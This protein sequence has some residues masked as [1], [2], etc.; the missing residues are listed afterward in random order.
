MGRHREPSAAHWLAR[1][2]GIGVGEA[3][4]TLQTAKELDELP[5]TKSALRHGELSPRQAHLVAQAASAD[6][7]AEGIM[8][9]AAK[10][11]SVPE[12]RDRALRTRAAAEVDDMA[13]YR[14]VKRG[15]HFRQ[16][17]DADGAWIGTIRDTPEV[18]ALVVAA[19]ASERPGIFEAARAAGQRDPSEAYDADAFAEI[20]RKHLAR[21]N[22]APVE[23]CNGML[24]ERRNG[25]PPERGE[26]KGL[27]FSAQTRRADAPSTAAIEGR[28]RDVT[29]GRPGELPSGTT[30]PSSE[31]GRSE[32]S[33]SPTTHDGDTAA[34]SSEGLRTFRGTAA[35]STASTREAAPPSGT[36]TSKAGT[37]QATPAS[38]KRARTAN[39]NAA[40]SSC[41]EDAGAELDDRR[42]TAPSLASRKVGHGTGSRTPL[43]ARIDHGALVR[44][45][46]EPGELCEITGVGP[47]PVTVVRD[48]L[49]HAFLAAV[50]TSPD[51][52]VLRVAHLGRASRAAREA[53]RRFVAPSS[54]AG[55]PGSGPA[56]ARFETLGASLKLIVRVPVDAGAAGRA[57][58]RSPGLPGSPAA[59]E[60]DVFLV[61]LAED[62]VEI[63]SAAHHTR[64][65]RVH[66]R[67][68]LEFRDPC[69]A[70][71]GC[72]A[73]ARLE[74]DHREEWSATHATC[75]DGADRLC[76]AHHWL[77][78]HRG[79]RLEPGTGKRRLLPP[80]GPT[81][82]PDPAG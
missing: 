45:R 70:V 21:C 4:T 12:L 59:A 30:S 16:R 72:A 9:E 43:L 52:A 5:A 24:P 46:C 7:T 35:P 13:R 50:A 55:P 51:G 80:R 58:E 53:A 67:T 36:G 1:Q 19:L 23:R 63:G 57:L 14:A 38:G 28:C 31:I 32:P 62:G 20:M 71:L 37:S 79:Y 81:A 76:H 77:K 11:E 15:R 49:A 65:F 42:Q 2:G 47:V 73:T 40:R 26:E 68:A 18:G 33:A 75:A 66:Q 78:T 22:G 8:L 44:G 69:C 74:L 56:S 10:R 6:R 48:L 34:S 17:T 54:G 64:K 27:P 39:V 61:A 3:V 41:E 82:R 25:T 60:R 29:E